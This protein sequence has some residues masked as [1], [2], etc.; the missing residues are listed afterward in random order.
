MQE[1]D[2]G[3]RFKTF[4]DSVRVIAQLGRQIGILKADVFTIQRLPVDAYG[5]AE[6]VFNVPNS[7]SSHTLRMPPSAMLVAKR[8][9]IVR[10]TEALRAELSEILDHAEVLSERCKPRPHS[11][12][13]GPRKA[14]DHYVFDRVERDIREVIKAVSP[15]QQRAQLVEL[16]RPHAPPR[17]PRIDIA[18]SAPPPAYAR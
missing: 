4:T 17:R 14:T 7:H 3:D 15:Q 1:V 11:E 16:N 18:G 10:A 9:E 5:D 6:A 8:G 13:A 12:P 2:R